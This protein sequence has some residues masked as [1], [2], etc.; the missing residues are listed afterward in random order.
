MTPLDQ[1]INAAFPG[2]VVRKDLTSLVKGNAVVPTFVLEYLLGQ[3]CAT[4]EEETIRQGV[5]TVKKILARHYVHREES[6]LLKSRIRDKGRDR[7]I[8]R[9]SVE[10]DDRQ[11]VHV[12]TFTNLGLKKVPVQDRWVRKFPKLLTSGVWCLVDV[13]YEAR[14][15]RDAVPWFIDSI[16]PIQLSAFDYVE[17]ILG[18][19]QFSTGEWMD[20]LIQTIGFNPEHFSRR[21]KLLQLSRLIPFVERNFNTIELGPKGTGK[22]HVYSEFSPHGMLISGGEVTLA[23]LFVNNASGKIGLVGFWDSVAFDEFAGPDKRVSKSLVDVMKNYMANKT[24]SRGRESLGAEASMVFIG[25]TKRSVGYMLKH[26]DLFEQLPKAYYDTAFLDRLH[27]YLPGW[28]VDIIR[29]EMFTSGF[30]FI[31]DYLA[32]AFRNLRS[33]DYGALYREHFTL[34]PT[35]ATRDR[36]AVQKTFGGLMKIIYPEGT[37]TREECRELLEFAIEGR[38]RVK[39]QLM[40]LDETF[41]ERAV[42]FKYL[43]KQTGKEH[44][45]I[46]L[47]ELQ[48]QRAL[49]QVPG[50]EQARSKE[51][52]TGPDVAT[53][54]STTLLTD[55]ATATLLTGINIIVKDNQRGVSYENLFG[56][57]LKNAREVHVVD[58]YLRQFHQIKNLQEFA[59]LLYRYKDPGDEVKLHV[60]TAAKPEEHVEVEKLLCKLEVALATTGIDLSFDVKDH[61]DIHD[62]CVETDTG[63]KII[64]GR[65]LDIFQPYDRKE[66]FNPA[67]ALQEERACKG[68]EVTILAV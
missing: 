55:D 15:E 21:G 34:D 17:Y 66:T 65:G 32:E 47:E 40:K 11:D 18:R 68:F 43:D 27:Y 7:V 36:T 51:P 48:Y 63:Y 22:S 49:T 61:G 67:V 9:V 62:R 42:R 24:F 35:I 31:V 50:S 44:E 3:Y 5:E 26:S 52:I 30:G 45:V 12:A 14:E 29:G 25:N 56:D 58:P 59:Q 16:K 38:R 41:R 39:L 10:L 20:V 1:Q 23:K 6:E 13:S 60:I 8:D 33:E 37:C 57:Y 53:D 2:K 54:P 4:D 64:L 28:E 46:T 19:Q